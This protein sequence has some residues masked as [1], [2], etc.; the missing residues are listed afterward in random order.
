MLTLNQT[1]EIL[2]NFTLK[3][4]ALGKNQSNNHFRFGDT[5]EVDGASAAPNYPLMWTSIIKT[6]TTKAGL[7]TRT[8]QIDVS[9][10]VNNDESNETHVLSD[11]ELVLMDLA[12][13]LEI[14]ADAGDVKM[15][16]GEISQITHYTEGRNDAPAGCYFTV[17]IISHQEGTSCNLPI[18]DG[19]IFDGNYIYTN[20][21]FGGGCSPVVIK[22]QDGNILQTF[23]N[24][25]TYTVTIVSAIDGGNATTVFTNTVIGN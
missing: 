20:G 9:D 15:Q 12:N 19:N 11:T 21:S 25:G 8:F 6:V 18:F 13:Y 14:I 17:D 16:L 23:T 2:K 7:V 4:K 10:K 1:I 5:W 24:G 22:D 3:H